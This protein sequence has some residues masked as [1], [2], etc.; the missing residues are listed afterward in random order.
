MASTCLHGYIQN[1]QWC[2]KRSLEENIRVAG[3][4]RL[5][6]MSAQCRLRSIISSISPLSA[7][8]STRFHVYLEIVILHDSNCLTLQTLHPH[9]YLY[10]WL[11]IIG[12]GKLLSRDVAGALTPGLGL[13]GHQQKACY[14]L[15]PVCIVN[16]VVNKR[17]LAILCGWPG[18]WCQRRETRQG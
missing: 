13:A 17:H 15:S 1:D 3:L 14:W 9:N 10:R 8:E 5:S 12:A 2:Y 18:E 6:L 16:G 4:I 7:S 11:I